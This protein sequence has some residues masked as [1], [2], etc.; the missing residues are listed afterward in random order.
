MEYK[1]VHG[2]GE[3]PREDITDAVRRAKPMSVVSDKF[4]NQPVVK[5]EGELLIFNK[6]LFPKSP[7]KED[8][9]AKELSLFVDWSGKNVKM[10]LLGLY[11]HGRTLSF[12][13]RFSDVYGNVYNYVNIKGGGIPK[14][15]K[16]GFV[17]NNTLKKHGGQVMGL[18]GS[19][20]S[21][22]DWDASNLFIE[23]GIKTS[24]PIAIIEIKEFITKDGERLSTEELRKQGILKNEDE[25]HEFT[26]VI[27]L[28]AFSEVMRVGDARKEDVEKFAKEH[29]MAS[30]EYVAWWTKK[31][32]KNVAKIH[33]L[34]KAHRNLI[35]HNI[36]VDGCIVDNDT[37]T[38]VGKSA[39]ISPEKYAIDVGNILFD[40]Y[41]LLTLFVDVLDPFA[42]RDSTSTL[43]EFREN[44]L[45]EYVESR[46][47]MEKDEFQVLHSKLAYA[48]KK[49]ED[50]PGNSPDQ[51]RRCLKVVEEAFEKKFGERLEG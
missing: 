35:G 37:V 8:K 33:D 49:A 10:D 21:A 38:N 39:R 47:N 16:E 34:G 29:G 20:D 5:V 32:A 2:K 25:S 22:E 1:Q 15:S 50:L 45:R 13:V 6:K 14:K 9:I 12:N 26:P 40:D 41:S 42:R 24:A 17:H 36:T 51:S 43:T 7:F 18:V 19:I 11:E 28:R 48:L 4:F 3:E 44:F 31:V 27:Y 46:S 30:D 23:N